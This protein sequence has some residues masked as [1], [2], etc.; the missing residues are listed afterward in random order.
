[1]GARSN[2]VSQEAFNRRMGEFVRTGGMICLC[3][4]GTIVLGALALA[5]IVRVVGLTSSLI[6]FLVGLVVKVFK[7]AMKLCVVWIGFI[8]VRRFW[9]YCCN[10]IK[11]RLQP[12]PVAL[13]D[14]CTCSIC[15]EDFL[16][17]NQ[18]DEP[19]GDIAEGEGA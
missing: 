15:L 8:A 16:V 11:A 14:Q 10:Y 3:I 4:V 7:A 2:R 12:P 17:L 9:R 5:F 6:S 18:D 19:P 1:M 13:P